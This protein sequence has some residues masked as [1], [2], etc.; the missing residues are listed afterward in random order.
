MDFSETHIGKRMSSAVARLDV[1]RASLAAALALALPG[2]AGCA[3]DPPAG[4]PPIEVTASVEASP[5]LNPDR[6]NRPSPVV[7]VVYGLADDA[8]FQNAG[9]FELYEQ[10]QAT[11]GD[12]IKSRQ[13]FIIAPGDIKDLDLEIDPAATFLAVLGA[14]RDI[15]NARFSA[16][17]PL[18]G[19]G[20]PLAI[21][22]KLQ[23]NSIVLVAPEAPVVVDD[24]AESGDGS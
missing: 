17:T 21:Q 7:V 11:L 13:E 4:P 5:F 8:K 10:E 9:F 2:L 20:D 1:R 22:I 6:T 16:I 3:D 14:F 15:D 24:A 12:A 23:S 19:G 18:P